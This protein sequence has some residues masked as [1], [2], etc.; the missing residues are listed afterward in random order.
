MRVRT[1]CAK[2]DAG[3]KRERELRQIREE[4]CGIFDADGVFKVSVFLRL[5]P[6]RF[7]LR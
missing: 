2:I 5:T 4:P 6:F 7:V 1:V 3:D